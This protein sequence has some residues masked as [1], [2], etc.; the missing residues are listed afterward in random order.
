MVCIHEARG[1]NP[2]RSTIFLFLAYLAM[3][4]DNEAIRT[5]LR[6]NECIN[7]RN[8]RGLGELITE[9]HTFIDMPSEIHTARKEMVVG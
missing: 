5:M 4:K 6:F 7:P 2:L 9:D 3:M 1:S 8:L